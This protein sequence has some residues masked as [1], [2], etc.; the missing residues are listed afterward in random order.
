MSDLLSQAHGV[1]RTGPERWLNLAEQLPL[2]LIRRPAAD[3]EWSAFDCLSHVLDTE[4]IFRSR[5]QAFLDGQDFAAFDTDKEGIDRSRETPHRL[6]EDFARYR[7]ENLA[8]LERLGP[9]DLS[10]TANHSEL[11]R[12]TLGELVNEWAA[13]DL[14]HTV[15]AERALMQSFVAGSGPWRSFFSDHD[16]GGTT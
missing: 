5:I 1:L 4:Q 15:Q 12:V 14:M 16:L 9:N 6:A 13:H 7:A 8:L 11:G 3:G 2:E 10:R